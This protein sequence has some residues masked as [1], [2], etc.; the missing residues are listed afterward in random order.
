MVKMGDR[1]EE[2]VGEKF[3]SLIDKLQEFN[4]RLSETV[5][6]IKNGLLPTFER[7]MADMQLSIDK[8]FDKNS[9]IMK[10]FDEQTEF[11]NRNIV[12]GLN[13]I[14][15]IFDINKLEDIM[16][17]ANRINDIIA[18]ELKGADILKTVE[19]LKNT[20]NKLNKR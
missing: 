16:T 12:E 14:K 1:G 18:E 17:R 10:K 4:M 15:A 13:G 3:N 11:L 6:S 19:E 8:L 2:S 9:Q 20:I 7:S 5:N